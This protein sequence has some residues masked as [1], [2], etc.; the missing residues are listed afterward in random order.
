M[1]L[2]WSS[3]GPMAA[4]GAAV[5]GGLVKLLSLGGQRRKTEAEIGDSIFTRATTLMDKQGKQIDQLQ[6]L[7]EQQKTLCE[8]L[9]A[10]LAACRERESRSS[11]FPLRQ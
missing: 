8:Q 3:L 7:C 2:D 4:V 9:R 6:A 11:R 10:E 1:S 5:G